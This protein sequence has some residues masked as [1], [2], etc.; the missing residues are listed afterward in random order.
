MFLCIHCPVGV[1]GFAWYAP[2]TPVHTRTPRYTPVH[3]YTL[4][5]TT[6]STAPHTHT[7]HVQVCGQHLG[8]VA[9]VCISCTSCHPCTVM[10]RIRGG[11]PAV[12][13]STVGAA[14]NC[15]IVGVG[16]AVCGELPGAFFW[17][18]VRAKGMRA[19]GN[20]GMCVH[21]ALW[22]CVFIGTCGYVCMHVYKC[23]CLH[24]CTIAARYTHHAQSQTKSTFVHQAVYCTTCTHQ[25]VSYT[26]CTMLR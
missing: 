13:P 10:H 23:V 11:L 6:V 17:Q 26:T 18:L 1:G 20:V 16:V 4:P 22:V 5:H 7:P 25:A 2:A 24:G 19:L 15:N 8:R 3:T 21:W 12:Y 14:C 9:M